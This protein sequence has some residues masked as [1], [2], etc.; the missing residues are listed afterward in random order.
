MNKEKKLL[1]YK[2]YLSSINKNRMDF[3]MFYTHQFPS[4]L[5]LSILS[6][7]VLGYI[8][9]DILFFLFF[10]E[11]FNNFSLIKKNFV[12]IIIYMI[13]IILYYCYF[14]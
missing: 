3:L 8:H 1:F 4:S 13:N 5:H 14:Y 12:F 7:Q 10:L 11:V 2:L 9:Y 6:A